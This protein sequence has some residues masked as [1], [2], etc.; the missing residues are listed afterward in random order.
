MHSSYTVYTY[1]PGS[2]L[3]ICY[4]NKMNQQGIGERVSFKATAAVPNIYSMSS[5]SY[6]LSYL[7]LSLDLPKETVL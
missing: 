3:W 1:A 7:S 2:R 4:M 6:P 5:H